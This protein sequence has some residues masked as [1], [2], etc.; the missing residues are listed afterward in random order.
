MTETSVPCLG[1]LLPHKLWRLETRLHDWKRKYHI[2]CDKYD[3]PAAWYMT[4]KQKLS[5]LTILRCILSSHLGLLNA[6]QFLKKRLTNGKHVLTSISFSKVLKGR[7]WR[8][9]EELF[10]KGMTL[11][12]QQ[13]KFHLNS[14]FNTNLEKKYVIMLIFCASL[15]QMSFKSSILCTQF[16]VQ[17]DEIKT[18]P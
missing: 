2:N 12:S 15:Q 17:T 13:L 8:T 5:S 16:L 1:Q 6:F 4:E 14:S 11:V 3:M 18:L 7:D 10:Y 9:V